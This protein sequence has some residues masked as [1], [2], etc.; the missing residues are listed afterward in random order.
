MRASSLTIIIAAV[1]AARASH[2]STIAIF[3]YG[4]NGGTRQYVRIGGVRYRESTAPPGMRGV[5]AVPVRDATILRTAS[6]PPSMVV[7]NVRTVSPEST[8]LRA[9]PILPDPTAL[10]RARYVAPAAHHL[11]ITAMLSALAGAGAG[12]SR[13]AE[14]RAW[15]E[16]DGRR[17]G[18]AAQSH[19]GHFA[20]HI[21]S[22]PLPAGA[23]TVELVA[24]AVRGRWCSCPPAGD[25]FV[26]GRHLLAWYHHQDERKVGA[27]AVAMETAAMPV[28]AP[29]R[30]ATKAASVARSTVAPRSSLRERRSRCSATYLENNRLCNT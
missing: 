1:A 18:E 24:R 27:V 14:L 13:T 26:S 7:H 20:L 8:L 30:V 15:V 9:L 19:G 10:E 22:L 29:V 28:L 25:G 2:T 16:V 23:H 5:F 12:A 6:P 4:G 17:V 21:A 3:E 11:S